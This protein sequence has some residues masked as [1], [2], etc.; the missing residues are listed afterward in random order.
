MKKVGDDQIFVQV[1]ETFQAISD[2]LVEQA[3]KPEI[4]RP[5]DGIDQPSLEWKKRHRALRPKAQSRPQPLDVQAK[6]VVVV[7]DLESHLVGRPI[8]V[9]D[10]AV[11]LNFQQSVRE[12]M[13]ERPPQ[14]RL[15]ESD[16]ARDGT[17]RSLASGQQGLLR[18]RGGLIETQGHRRGVHLNHS[19]PHLS[20]PWPASLRQL[21]V[22]FAFKNSNSPVFGDRKTD[23]AEFSSFPGE[24]RPAVPMDLLTVDGTGPGREVR[25]VP[26]SHS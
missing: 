17:A 19:S 22:R 11:S 15:I 3:A 4:E 9:D 10:A 12:K 1:L 2:F 26:V 25:L 8:P 16:D 7:V 23:L 5:D 24:C 21:P 20:C 14:Q 13:L 18:N 6:S